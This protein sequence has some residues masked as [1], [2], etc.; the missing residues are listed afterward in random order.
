MKKLLLSCLVWALATSSLLA[1]TAPIAVAVQN[2]TRNYDAQQG[3]AAFDE[4]LAPFLHGV[5]SGDPLQDRVIIWTRITTDATGPITADWQVASDA[6][7]SDIVASGT[8]E[9]G[10]ENDYTVKVD[11]TGLDAETTYYYNFTHGGE[12]SITGRTRTAAIDA[13]HLRFAV[14]SCSNY[15]AGY[16]NAYR[17][18]AYRADLDAVIHLGDYYYEYAEGEYGYADSIGRGHEPDHEI[19]T[20]EDYRT[21][22]NF[23]KLD[24]DLRA[25]H[26]QHPF[27]VT[28]DDHETANDAY[29]DGAENHNEEEGE[30]TWEERKSYS[31]QAYFEWMPIRDNE[32]QQVYRTIDYGSLANLVMIDT[33]IEGRTKQVDS[34]DAP[35]FEDEDRTLLGEE[36]LAWF[37]DELD[38]SAATSQWTLVGNQVVFS[39]IAYEF[40][41]NLTAAAEQIIVDIWSGYPAEQA[42]VLSHIVDNELNNLAFLTGDVH[43]SFAFDTTLD[44]ENDESYDPE[45]GEG[46]VAVEFVTPS[47]TSPGYDEVLG[48]PVAGILEG[49][50]QANNPQLKK[51]NVFDHGY[52]ILDVTTERL[53]ADWY[54]IDHLEIPEAIESY[55]NGLYTNSGDNYLQNADAPAPGKT[56]APDLVPF[57][58]GVETPSTAAN[59]FTILGSYPNP[60]TST[61]TINYGLNKAEQIDIS[62]FDVKGKKVAQ[63]FEGQQTAGLYSL[64][65]N[66]AQFPKGVYVYQL[67]T[68][69]GTVSRKI[70]IQ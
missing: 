34:L 14:V 21:R 48:A 17:Y 16:F 31:K 63:V 44:P 25:I 6:D 41:V 60:A 53:Q 13:D 15:Q 18:I 20:L 66:V 49:S 52:Y 70:V 59:Q 10:M 23:Y 40:L 69:N 7:M 39:P 12:T 11:V 51:A 22:H 46:S 62:L 19:S 68:K 4:L 27:I 37:K 32:N 26:Q 54:Y 45:T 28:W 57:P 8:V 47:I 55:G 9:T 24:A 67:A 42:N 29:K 30:G 65:F 43:V 3:L 5:A 56:D 35:N 61:H 2:Q 38:N 50:M 1:Q 58:V 64:T 36:Q 33:R